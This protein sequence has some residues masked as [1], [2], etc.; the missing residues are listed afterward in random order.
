VVTIADVASL[1][2]V[3]RATASR[4]LNPDTRA[5]VNEHT[6]RRGL[7]AAEALGYLPNRVAR[8]VITGRSQTVG[9]VVPDI[10]M[11]PFAEL[12][13]G[14]QDRLETD[15]FAT[16]LANIDADPGRERAALE[17]L[18]S[19]CV[20]GILACAAGSPGHVGTC[21][22]LTR[23][24]KPT[25]LVLD[26][27]AAAEPARAF[28]RA[29]SGLLMEHVEGAVR[30]AR[31]RRAPPRRQPSTILRP[32]TPA[33]MRARNTRRISVAGSPSARMPA[34]ATPVAPMPT[35]TA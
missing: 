4:A 19:R 13:R 31:P 8:A 24:G 6:A 15:G 26:G 10:S 12:V 7:D 23:E 33:T 25:G 32:A 28:G 29:V 1:A 30:I 3:H 21:R 16:L 11:P 18:V 20:D 2:G 9:V 27:A 22:V 34:T 17:A 5:L 14:V 35:H